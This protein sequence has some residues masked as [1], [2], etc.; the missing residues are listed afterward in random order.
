MQPVLHRH[1]I[2]Q[3][4]WLYNWILNERYW[5][6]APY[7][8]DSFWLELISTY[9]RTVTKSSAAKSIRTIKRRISQL[10]PAWHVASIKSAQP[11]ELA[12]YEAWGE[13]APD[14]FNKAEH[15][16][17]KYVQW[18]KGS[19]LLFRLTG[20]DRGWRCLWWERWETNCDPEC[21]K[22]ARPRRRPAADKHT[23]VT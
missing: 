14:V 5:S 6:V 3:L 13:I 2:I 23:T 9:K 1:F 16:R 20:K 12:S 21:T 7:T 4:D 22:S 8:M 17:S 11:V 10:L 19:V 15:Q 18:N